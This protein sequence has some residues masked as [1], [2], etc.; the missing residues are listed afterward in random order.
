LYEDSFFYFRRH[1]KSHTKTQQKQEGVAQNV[2]ATTE[3]AAAITSHMLSGTSWFKF[4][5]EVPQTQPGFVTDPE[6]SLTMTPA[7]K[8]AYER[9]QEAYDMI[10]T[11]MKQGRTACRDLNVF[12]EEL[13]I[14]DL[15]KQY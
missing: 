14:I 4:V 10:S 5:D 12:V 6:V 8:E 11:T 7:S 13:D 1:V 2:A 3:E 15:A 9:M